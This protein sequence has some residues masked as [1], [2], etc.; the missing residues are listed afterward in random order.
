MQYQVPQFIE[1]EDKIFGPL[2]LKQFIYIGG[3]GGFAFI[4]WRFL[5]IIIALP[6]ALGVL[7][8]AAALAF[9]KVN[10][11]PLIEMIESG[12]M[13]YIHSKLYLWKAAREKKKKQQDEAAVSS[14]IQVPALSENK[15]K[16]LAWSLDINEHIGVE[17]KREEV[18]L[19]KREPV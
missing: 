16:D 11:R 2:T 7:G 18:G 1:V 4:L 5:P 3:G 17:R 12:F 19:P 9:I 6:V 8:L 15:L 13:Y 14:E 10:K